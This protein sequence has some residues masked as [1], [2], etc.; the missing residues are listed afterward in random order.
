MPNYASDRGVRVK[1]HV[2]LIYERSLCVG[3]VA[4]YGL[5]KNNFVQKVMCD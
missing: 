4:S 3:K 5:S 2:T 1:K